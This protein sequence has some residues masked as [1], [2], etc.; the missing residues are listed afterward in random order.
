ML[1]VRHRI[2]YFDE[3]KSMRAE[4]VITGRKVM[5]QK[6]L[7]DHKFTEFNLDESLQKG[8]QDAEFV[9]CTPI[10][11]A[12]L[13]AAL[14]GRDVAGQAQ[15]GT[16]KTVAFLLACCHYL[17]TH[18]AP[19][20][21]Q[22]TQPRALMLAPT[23]ELA[24]QIYRD[25]EVLAR[26]TGFTLGLVYGGT[27][28][29]EQKTMLAG[30]TDILIGTPGR[31]I[32]F[33]RQGLYDLK[34]A[35]VAVL[36][37]AD[38]MFDLGFIKDI[39]FLL[40]RM[41]PANSRLNLLFS[42]TL[43]FKVMELAYEHLNNPEEIK[44]EGDTVVVDKVTEYSFYPADEEKMPLLVN[45]LKRDNHE[46]IL[47]FVNTRHGVEKVAAIL[48]A[49]GISNGALSGDV[50]QHKREQLLEAF[51]TGTRK[52]L[53]ATDV[54]A[55]GLH[56][57]DVSHVYNFDLP[58]DADDYIHRIGRTARAGASGEAISF[59]CER[60]AY[61]IM[62]IEE[63]IGHPLPRKDIGPE[64]LES[65]QRSAAPRMRE[66]REG[67]NRDRNQDRGRAP[68]PRPGM[69]AGTDKKPQQPPNG[70]QSMDKSPSFDSPEPLR[71]GT[72]ASTDKERQ[73][74]PDGN[75][76]MA[77]PPGFDS[78]EPLRP[79]TIAS[80]DKE[81]QQ[82]PD[83]NQSMAKPPG[84]DSPEPLRPGTIASTDKESQQPPDS[85]Q[86]LAKPPGFDSPEP[87]RPGTI[88]S[89][90]KEPQQP[91]N[92]NQ[93]T[94]KS[95]GFDSPE[96]LAPRADSAVDEMAGQTPETIPAAPVEN[97]RNQPVPAI[98][99]ASSKDR[100]SRR[101]GEIPAIG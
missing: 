84:F 7:T 49:N 47:V 28:Y 20:G 23:R 26:H 80:T 43:S 86:S 83:G 99:P 74:P 68:K 36:D 96:P 9:Y 62:E 90:D 16:G 18:P 30:G 14:E 66:R 92:G 82:P 76:S 13:P 98:R 12:C 10:Q 19:P 31:L 63:H 67:E 46:R 27:G 44:I 93:S 52:V 45:L 89:T 71:P 29:D 3:N 91:L 41:P 33:F 17:L 1:R 21:R 81:P 60:Y 79:G 56:I 34:H 55:R 6:H 59:V 58:Q 35:Q 87:L 69:I 94:A 11:A 51:K 24:I 53:V 65:I 97:Q 37:E 88:A 95:P 32:D 73:Q 72:I 61:S 48:S 100:F 40:R 15:T 42:A 4:A 2:K 57:P 22:R 38:R 85:N 50:P 39:R 77:K 25:A 101:Y 8:L 70:N 78:P 54:A 75:Q 5:S 64:L